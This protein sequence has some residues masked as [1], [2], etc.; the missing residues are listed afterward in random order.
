MPAEI[1]GGAGGERMSIEDEGEPRSVAPKKK[2]AVKKKKFKRAKKAAKLGPKGSGGAAKFP[3]QLRSLKELGKPS[4]RKRQVTTSKPSVK[5]FWTRQTSQKS[6]PTI[7]AST[8]LTMVFLSMP[9][10]INSRSLLRR[11]QSSKKSFSHRCRARSLSRRRKISTGFWIRRQRPTK[12]LL[13]SK[14]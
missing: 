1:V 9:S 14:S 3:R 12:A 7:G 8:F 13:Q 4:V 5:R 10:R 6:T 11:S 2:K